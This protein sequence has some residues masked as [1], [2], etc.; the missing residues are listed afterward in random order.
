MGLNFWIVLLLLGFGFMV[1]FIFGVAMSA[2]AASREKLA[3]SKE[4]V[5]FFIKM[6]ALGEKSGGGN[7]VLEG[8]REEIRKRE[9]GE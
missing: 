4:A 6:A 3:K 5:D 8:I 9:Q 7:D 1:G 2:R